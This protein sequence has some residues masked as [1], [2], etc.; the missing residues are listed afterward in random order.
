MYIYVY[1]VYIFKLRDA[2]IFTRSPKSGP[3][4]SPQA[5]RPPRSTVKPPRLGLQP[6]GRPSPLAKPAKPSPG[7]FRPAL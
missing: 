5:G 6:S 1:S 2:D 4:P 3:Q 7:H